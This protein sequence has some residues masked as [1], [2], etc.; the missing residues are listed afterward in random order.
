MVGIVIAQVNRGL[1]SSFTIRNSLE[2]YAFEMEFNVYNPLIEE[3]E[4]LRFAR[5]KQAKLYYLRDRHVTPFIRF[6]LLSS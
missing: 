1:A 3:V 4:V 2:G 5:R 6:Q